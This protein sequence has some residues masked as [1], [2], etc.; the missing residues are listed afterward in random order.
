M[1]LT[2]SCDACYSNETNSC[3]TWIIT[4]VFP[5][6][7]IHTT[8]SF[9]YL[10][11]LQGVTHEPSASWS[12]AL[13]T[14]KHIVHWIECLISSNITY[15]HAYLCLE[16]SFD[17]KSVALK[18]FTTRLDNTK[19][20]K[21]RLSSRTW[22]LD[23]CCVSRNT[24]TTLNLLY[25]SHLMQDFSHTQSFTKLTKSQNSLLH[26]LVTIERV[27]DTHAKF[28]SRVQVG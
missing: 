8:F 18:T 2:I 11:T 21:T 22:P 28:G 17:M 19:E 14:E 1:A 4:H 12:L 24:R 3:T 26:F 23:G 20:T 7:P 27:R 5:W 16:P 25:K 9:Y 15:T 13:H 6:F 10:L